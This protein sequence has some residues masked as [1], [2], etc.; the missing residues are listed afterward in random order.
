ML[1]SSF[2]VHSAL[3]TQVKKKA[4]EVISMQNAKNE[5]QYFAG[6]RGPTYINKFNVSIRNK[7]ILVMNCK[8]LLGVR[9]GL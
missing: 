3:R 8:M 7:G 4:R 6:N 5:R 1:C 9:G 2:S